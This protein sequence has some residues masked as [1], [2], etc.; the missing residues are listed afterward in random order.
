MI[1]LCE[2]CV[3]RCHKGHKGI[4]FVRSA[5]VICSC[6]SHG[7]II[8]A[9]CCARVISANQLEKQ[10]RALD[11]R[12]E[13]KR[14]REQNSLM[15]LVFAPVPRYDRDNKR[16]VESGWMLCRRPPPKGLAEFG[17]TIES[18]KKTPI[19]SKKNSN[20]ELIKKGSIAFDDNNS[21]EENI[22]KISPTKQNSMLINNQDSII[23]MESTA[24]ATGSLFENVTL[25]DSYLI[26]LQE[27]DEFPF[28]PP[29]N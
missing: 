7:A 19:I 27:T 8:D 12:G 10:R 21:I 6:S 2:P 24:T 18:P 3:F 23:S 26:S 9:A 13:A 5:I 1:K 25:P 22:E 29:S 20:N 15:P 4:R 16:K 14:L 11:F 28:E 17:T